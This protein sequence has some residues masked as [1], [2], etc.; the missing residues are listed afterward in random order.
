MSEPSSQPG[1]LRHPESPALAGLSASALAARMSAIVEPPMRVAAMAEALAEGPAEVTA[2]LVGE[3]IA[4][5]ADATSGYRLALDA[6]LLVLSDAARLAYERRAELYAAAVEAGQPEVALMLLDAAPHD[7]GTEVLERQLGAERPL[8]PTGRPLTLGERKSLAR[9]HRRDLLL[10]LLRDPHP[11]VIAVL[12]D[13]PH[14]T[15]SDVLRLASRRPMLPAALAT[16]SASRR[17]RARPRVRRALVL[18]PFTAIP[19]AAQLSTTLSDADLHSVHHDP[20][21][22][23]RLRDHARGILARRRAAAVSV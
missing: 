16:I 8:V 17:W 13:N 2:C 9:T 22:H 15:E 3:L 10:Q 7:P 23:E 21:L 4:R 11:D 1:G 5:A 19:L 20:A 14:L 12:L 18:N 6:I